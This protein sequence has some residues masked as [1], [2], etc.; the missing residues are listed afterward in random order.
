MRDIKLT[1]HILKTIFFFMYKKTVIVILA[2]TFWL[3]VVPLMEWL[4][5]SNEIKLWQKPNK[6]S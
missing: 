6:E 5:Y 3:M 4:M 1:K 2:L